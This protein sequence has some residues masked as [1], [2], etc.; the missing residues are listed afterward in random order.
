MVILSL[1]KIAKLNFT[2]GRMDI[3]LSPAIPINEILF[4]IIIVVVISIISALQ[5]ALKASR[6]EPAVA[7]RHV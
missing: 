4:T 3:S 2:F 7:L 6:L 5:P 1:V